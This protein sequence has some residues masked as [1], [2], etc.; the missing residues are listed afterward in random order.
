MPAPTTSRG[1]ATARIFTVFRDRGFEGA[2]RSEIARATGLGKSSLYHYFPNGKDDMV[3]AVF[4]LLDQWL[5]ENV[6]KPFHSPGTP[7]QRLRRMLRALDE[8]H[9]GG[10]NAC[11]LGA[12]VGGGGTGRAQ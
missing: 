12:L 3:L 4:E 5:E 10:R 6:L 8:L 2:T 11:G 7:A 1:E 9:D